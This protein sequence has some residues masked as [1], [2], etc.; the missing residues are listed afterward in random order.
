M[1]FFKAHATSK[2]SYLYFAVVI[3]QCSCEGRIY[4]LS[5]ICGEKYPNVPPSVRFLTKINMNGVSSSG[6]VRL[7]F[8]S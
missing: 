1:M 2:N 5:L 3:M 6:E 8:V 4:G 7:I